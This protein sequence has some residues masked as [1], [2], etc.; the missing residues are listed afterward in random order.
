MEYLKI[1]NGME[2]AN[3]LVEEF[4]HRLSFRLELR[5]VCDVNRGPYIFYVHDTL[6]LNPSLLF[7]YPVENH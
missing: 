5:M 4:F 3:S 2:F 1:R 7:L 6:T